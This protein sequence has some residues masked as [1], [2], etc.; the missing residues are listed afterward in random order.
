[1][2]M[3]AQAKPYS[4]RR[5]QDSVASPLSRGFGGDSGGAGS[6]VVS[7]TSTGMA[8]TGDLSSSAMPFSV[9]APS[10][11]NAGS[12]RSSLLER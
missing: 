5:G 7:M 2:G 6:A 3:H 12:S 9:V 11:L 10:G 1:M 4:Q 8:A